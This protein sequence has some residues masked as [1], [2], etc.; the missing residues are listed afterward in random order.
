MK[1]PSIR[2][3]P[4]ASRVAPQAPPA[5]IHGDGGGSSNARTCLS[6]SH[7]AGKTCRG[8]SAWSPCSRD[9]HRA[10]RRIVSCRI[11]RVLPRGGLARAKPVKISLMCSSTRR[12]ALHPRRSLLPSFHLWLERR[13]FPADRI[14]CPRRAFRLRRRRR[15]KMLPTDSYLPH[16]VFKDE[17]PRDVRLPARRGRPRLA[18]DPV[19]H[20]TGAPRCPVVRGGPR[21]RGGIHSGSRSIVPR[22]RREA[23]SLARA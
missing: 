6:A 2:S 23:R 21:S 8:R 22:A 12:T 17:H 14:A 9:D 5:A 4:L 11:L 10:P 19:V 16:S 1:P 3:R 15:S 13:P 7:G 18:G 20:A